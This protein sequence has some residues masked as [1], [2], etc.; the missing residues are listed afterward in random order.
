M[1]TSK[2]MRVVRLHATLH[3]RASECARRAG[4]SLNKWISMRVHYACNADEE[5]RTGCQHY[6]CPRTETRTAD[7]AY[8]E[9]SVPTSTRSEP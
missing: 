9:V 8:K 7:E 4:L 3:D 1:A 2:K 6:G 5:K